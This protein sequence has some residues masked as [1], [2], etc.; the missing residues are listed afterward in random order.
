VYTELPENLS[1]SYG[2][3][4]NAQFYFTR[5]KVADFPISGH[6]FQSVHVH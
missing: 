5:D 2:N 3:I 1:Y 6:I 4:A